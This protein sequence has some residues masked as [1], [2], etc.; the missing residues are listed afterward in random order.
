ML[1]TL[2]TQIQTQ[3]ASKRFWLAS[4]FPLLLFVLAS[5]WIL[6]RQYV[7]FKS[8]LGSFEGLKEQAVLYSALVAIFLAVAYIFSAM[9]STLLEWLEGR[10]G[11]ARLLKFW[12]YWHQ[13]RTLQ[14]IQ[15]QYDAAARSVNELEKKLESWIAQIIEARVA[16]DQRSGCDAKWHKSNEGKIVR[17]VLRTAASG[18]YIDSADLSTAVAAMTKLLASNSTT[19]DTRASKRLK[20]AYLAFKDAIFYAR[21]S[22]QFNRVL[23]YN[24]RQFRYPGSFESNDPSIPEAQ[25]QNV[26]A[27]TRMGNIG[28]TMRSYAITRYNLD[29]DIFWSRLQNSIQTNATTYFDVLQ[30]VKVQV[31]CLVSLVWL[32][33]IFSLVFTPWMFFNRTSVLG[34]AVAGAAGLLSLWLYSL[35]CSSYEVFADVMRGAVDLFR[36]RL[37]DDLHLGLPNGP[38]EERFLWERLGNMTGYARKE[39]IRYKHPGK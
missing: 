1:T 34:F 30:D 11:I 7:G 17:K 35:A 29:L 25:V 24:K 31:D 38:E 8:W 9:N 3:L 4:V 28:Q 16:G 39:I 21:D 22:S 37:L 18:Y 27:I 5:G 14:C 10:K 6:S 23:L 33:A 19:Q 26:L 32:S 2:L 20:A 12:F 36:F 13:R 15:E